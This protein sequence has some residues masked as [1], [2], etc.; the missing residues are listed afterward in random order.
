M[1]KEPYGLEPI[2]NLGDWYITL[3]ASPRNQFWG[4]A[5][6]RSGASARATPDRW[7]PLKA[8]EDRPGQ[9][10]EDRTAGRLSW[11]DSMLFIARQRAG[12]ETRMEP[13]GQTALNSRAVPDPGRCQGGLAG[14]TC[15]RW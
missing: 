3:N 9:V 12:V 8:P 5:T 7:R 14:F 10:P 6:C 11:R 13:L 15:R 1:D 4:V 2:S